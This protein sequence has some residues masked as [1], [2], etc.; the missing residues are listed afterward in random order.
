M[1][2]SSKA[3]SIPATSEYFC[4]ASAK[5]KKSSLASVTFFTGDI[6]AILSIAHTLPTTNP[7]EFVGGFRTHALSFFATNPCFF[8]ADIQLLSSCRL[9]VFYTCDSDATLF[10]VD[11][12]LSV[13]PLHSELPFE[14]VQ[15]WAAR[16]IHGIESIRLFRPKGQ[17]KEL[18]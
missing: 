6:S 13:L 12:H 4:L 11:S 9:H 18:V 5:L 2:A 10:L 7:S 15:L 17:Y 3:A 16:H 14:M 8:P 1:L